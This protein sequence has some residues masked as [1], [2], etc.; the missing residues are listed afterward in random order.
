MILFYMLLCSTNI[1][2]AQVLVT[3]NNN[4]PLLLVDLN[5]SD[6]YADHRLSY[7]L[8]D[9]AM[10]GTV[11]V[12]SATGQVY[13]IASLDREAKD[14]YRFKVHSTYISEGMLNILYYFY[15]SISVPII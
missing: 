14:A 9:Q 1:T 13:L 7:Q 4:T 15:M 8:T 10:A 2:Y 3:E 12:D 11:A 6:S 5:V